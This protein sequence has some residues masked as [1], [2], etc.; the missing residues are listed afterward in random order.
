MSAA[1]MT[2]ALLV[3]GTG[4]V[5]AQAGGGNAPADP[6]VVAYRKA[7][8]NSNG[9]HLRTLRALLSGDINLPYAVLEETAAFVTTAGLLS[10]HTEAD[11]F[12]PFPPGSADPSSRAKDEVWSD[13][14]GFAE[15]MDA[16]A[17]AVRQLNAVA[18]RGMNAK[19][20]EALGEVQ[21]TCGACHNPFRKPAPR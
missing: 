5:A 3:G 11:Y 15:R 14:D 17:A 20:L 10:H 19:T 1:A 4:S 12:D 8:M 21:A 9:Q 2:A 7:L 18:Q 13:A 6:A 16:F